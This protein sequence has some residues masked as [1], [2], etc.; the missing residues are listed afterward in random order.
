[1]PVDPLSGVNVISTLGEYFAFKN[2]LPLTEEVKDKIKDLFSEIYHEGLIDNIALSL[3]GSA[4]CLVPDSA[5]YIFI[6]YRSEMPDCYYVSIDMTLWDSELDCETCHGMHAYV[7]LPYPIVD[8]LDSEAFV[9]LLDDAF[10]IN[11][12]WDYEERTN[13]KREEVRR[14]KQARLDTICLSS[15]VID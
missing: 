6:D 14:A 2:K 15:D 11:W 1:M 4:Y 8:K 10:V 3:T 5:I 13:R 9:K 12:D 7:D